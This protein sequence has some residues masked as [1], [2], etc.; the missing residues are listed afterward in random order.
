MRLSINMLCYDVRTSHALHYALGDVNSR[1]GPLSSGGW[2][3]SEGVGGDLGVEPDPGPTVDTG[4]T[5]EVRHTGGEGLEHQRETLQNGGCHHHLKRNR[6]HWA[7]GI[8][9]LK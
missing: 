5:I 2:C 1:N 6:R 9:L 3:R 4:L 7:F 8:A